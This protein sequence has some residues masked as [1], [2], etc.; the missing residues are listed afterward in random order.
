M[1]YSCFAAAEAPVGARGGGGRDGRALPSSSAAAPVSSP[2]THHQQPMKHKSP[3]NIV[4]IAAS[5]VPL[6]DV[7]TAPTLPPSPQATTS[8]ADPR[9]PT[10][11]PCPFD[12]C[13]KLFT[14]KRSLRLHLDSAHGDAASAD[15]PSA[16]PTS[17][18]AVVAPP[19]LAVGEKAHSDAKRRQKRSV[20]DARMCATRVCVLRLAHTC[21]CDAVRASHPE[22]NFTLP[23]TI[24]WVSLCT[25]LLLSAA[26]DIWVCVRESVCVRVCA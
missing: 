2:P 19:S 21:L 4:S 25:L 12:N 3:N 5:G 26:C 7:A 8:Q 15:A 14:H 11:H 6:P 13:T 24:E 17:Q 16:A 23:E 1:D 10:L 20:A 9:V 18:L 22:L